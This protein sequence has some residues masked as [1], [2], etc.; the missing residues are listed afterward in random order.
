MI[1][2]ATLQDISQLNLLINSA[3]RGESSK[4]GWTTE[5]HLLGGL[6]TDET[7]L[8]ELLIKDNVTILKYSEADKII[9]SV[10]LEVQ[11][12]QLYLGMLTVS[13]ELQGGGVGKKLMQAAEEFAQENALSSIIMT[14]ISARK[15]LIEYYERRGYLNT[16][17]TKP[18]PMDDPKFGLPKQFLEFIV[19]QKILAFA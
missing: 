15:E 9:G 2:K 4:Q 18:F 5:E 10:Y 19:M 16:G 3:Y 11:N 12:E 13:P 17:E 1:S 6:R 8:A 14:V 7:D